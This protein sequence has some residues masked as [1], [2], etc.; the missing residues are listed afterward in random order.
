M[1][2]IL[3][4]SLKLNFTRKTLGCH[5]LIVIFK[6]GNIMIYRIPT[7]RYCRIPLIHFKIFKYLL[8]KVMLE[9]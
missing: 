6:D 9:V 8:V 4:I 3:L 2:K 5:G 1:G 7:L